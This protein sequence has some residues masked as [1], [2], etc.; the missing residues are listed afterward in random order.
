[1]VEKN[2][3]N[4]FFSYSDSRLKCEG[5]DAEELASQ[6]G[7]PL[8]VYSANSFRRQYREIAD[9]FKEVDPLICYAIKACSTLAVLKLL[10]EE[11]SGFDCVSKGDVMRALK[12]GAD[13]KKIVF[14]G[15]GKTEDEIEFA[16]NAD[17]LMFNVE[18]KPELELIS[19]VASRIKKEASIALRLLPDVDPQ[20]HAYTSTGAKGSKFGIDL[21]GAKACLDIIES[22]PSLQLKGFHFHIGSGYTVPD[23]QAEAV[24]RV[25]P[26][27]KESKERFPL[28]FLNVG[29]GY[30]ISYDGTSVP[31]AT[32]FA[33]HTVPA[34]KDLGLRIALEPGR[35]IAGN[36]GV[37]LCRTLFVKESMG[38]KFVVV[39][40][41]MNDLI[42]PSLYQAHHHIWPTATAPRDLAEGDGISADVV[43]PVCESGDF[44]AKSRRLPEVKSGDLMAVFSAGAYSYVMSSTYNTRP[45]AA[46]ILVEGDNARL[47]HERETYDDL[48]RPELAGLE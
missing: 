5:I 32:Q 38:D 2:V 15:V 43:G 37:M 10:K 48:F 23:K 31:S 36:S 44:L 27:V 16:L 4:D 11:G 34:L 46:E 19:R 7:T 22:S 45:R 18:S 40:A 33:E 25:A 30:G 26:F 41:A 24:T 17:I 12:V 13:P 1:M 47:I 9:A 14:A 42:R 20:V 39:D 8:Y 21:N 29:G 28:E 3:L 35:Y 6:F